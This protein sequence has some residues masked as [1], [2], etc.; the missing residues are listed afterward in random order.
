[1]D[2]GL[3]RRLLVAVLLVLLRGRL[4]CWEASGACGG[5]R[6]MLLLQEGTWKHKNRS[7]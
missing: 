6:R 1:V 7:F 2:Q 5:P 4:E 3:R